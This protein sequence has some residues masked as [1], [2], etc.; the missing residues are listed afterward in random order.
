MGRKK[1]ET[2]NICH[3]C[4]ND[5]NPGKHKKT[6]N[7]S[8]EC[9]KIFQELNKVDR[10]EKSKKGLEEKYGVSY[11]SQL[12]DFSK[13]VKSTKKQKYGDENFNNRNK[14]KETCLDKYGVE[15]SM[16]IES[17]KEKSKSTKK[18]KY[19]DEN[20]NNRNKAKETCLDKYGEE[21][22]LKSEEIL[23]K[24]QD[25]NFKKYGKKFTVELD[26]AKE[27]LKKHNLLNYNSEYFFS[28]E[29]YNNKSRIE[30]LKRIE[31]LL[32]DSDFIFDINQYD[33]LRTK[34]EDDSFSYIFYDIEC[35]KCKNIFKSRLIN[36]IPVC[37]KCNPII[38]NSKLHLEFREFLNELNIF[39]IEND[40][41][42]INPLELDFNIP[43]KKI[44]IELNGNYWH[45]EIGG[46]KN[47]NYHI[48]KTKKCLEKGIKLI[49]IFEDEWLFK[50]EIV[51]SR[52]KHILGISENKIFARKCEIKEIT[53]ND[54]ILFL[55]QNHIQ[56]N[57]IDK[58]RYGL[59][60]KE[61]L[62][63][64]M[65]FSKERI[66]TGNSFIEGNWELNR[67]CVKI[68]HSVI[69]SFEKLL[70]HFKKNNEY[71]KIVTYADCRWS[72]IKHENTVYT[73]NGFNFILR[74]RCSFFFVE[75]KDYFNRKHRF[76]LAK[77]KLI[78]L[79][80]NEENLTGWEIAIKNGYDRIWDCGTLKFELSNI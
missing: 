34:N 19:G 68:N 55:E 40:R 48:N 67:F 13:K 61:E 31:L 5:F 46:G 30:K 2:I 49:H 78:E 39:F 32:K 14:S 23:N 41:K 75:K 76:S 7:C 56:G 17:T 3:T 80:G 59:F 38:S 21:H 4:G 11:P 9:L 10:I 69:G 73:K 52:I 22:H 58:I 28:S 20:F 79:Y 53:L 64:V 70:S 47:K 77:H 43:E 50:K 37:R 57:S 65:T 16:M 42:T 51:K 24:M 44:A 6:K 36:E 45:S 35:K 54:K 25:T 63:S 1:I 18:E 66:V 60:Y 29:K 33:K 72:G 27:N 71:K 74:T 26:I 8:P 62:I 12:P 15:N